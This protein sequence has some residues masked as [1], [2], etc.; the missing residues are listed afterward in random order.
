[1]LND[2]NPRKSLFLRKKLFQRTGLLMTVDCSDDNLIQPES[3]A[4]GF[5]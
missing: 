2:D 4:V 5:L 3:F 1:M